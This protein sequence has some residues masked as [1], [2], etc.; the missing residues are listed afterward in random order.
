MSPANYVSRIINVITTII[1]GFLAF[2]FILKLFGANSANSFVGWVYDNT[3]V[4]L[5]PFR[6]IFPNPVVGR[7]YVL[8]FNTLF[9]IIVYAL[10]GLAA[11]AIVG[12][13]TVD[14]TSRPAKK[15]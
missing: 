9:A 2:R 14:R 15:R 6:G 3:A 1:V 13:F 4:L 7:H 11:L 8:E 12:I 10:I 5:D